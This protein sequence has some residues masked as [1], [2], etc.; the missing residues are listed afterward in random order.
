[1]DHTTWTDQTLSASVEV[2]DQEAAA[3]DIKTDEAAATDVPILM[4]MDLDVFNAAKEGKIDVLRGHDPQHLNQIL[5]PTSNTVLHVYIAYAITPKLVKPK[6]EAPIKPTSFV[7]D[8]LQ[9]CPT[10]LWQ[11]NKSGETALHMAAKHGLAEIV[12]LLIQTAK[13][14]RCED[15]E[16]GA[17]AFALSS[18]SEEEAASWKIFI[19]TP[20]K[21]KDT[22]LH[23]AVRFKHLGVVE[24]LIREDPDF[25]YP[26]N[27]AGE[28]PLYLAAERRYKALFSEIL[29]TCK[30]PTYQ[31]PIGRTALHAAVIHG[32]EEMT[33]EILNKK[34]D[35]AIVTDEKG[36]TPLHYAA[37]YG[38]ASIVTQLLEADK[39]SAYMGD[40]ADKKTALHIAA[41]K[42]HVN[43]MKQ[44]ISYCPDCCEVVDRRR[45]NALHYALEKRKPRIIEFVLMDTWLSNV[46]LNAKDVD[47]NTPLHLLNAPLY[48][49]TPF[50]GDDRVD[51][52]AFNKENMN[53]L[54]VIKANDDVTFK[55]YLAIVLKR[56]GASSGHRILSENDNDGQKLKENK[57]GEDTKGIKESHLVVAALVATVTFA[58]GVTMPGGY[59][60]ASDQ[61]NGTSNVS[62][63]NVTAPAPAPSNG[64]TPGYAV[65]TKNTAFQIFYSFDMI[66]LCFSTCSVFMHLFTLI[67][68]EAERSKFLWRFI[69][70]I[71]MVSVALMMG[72]FIAG[73][74]AVLGDDPS[75][76]Q[77][78]L[79]LVA[80]SIVGLVYVIYVEI[81][82]ENIFILQ[83]KLNRL[84]E[85]IKSRRHID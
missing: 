85:T 48:T 61:G 55:R 26:P 69:I 70:Q 59:Y 64:S 11:Q 68:P 45:R 6:E 67:R 42:G 34:K 17:A 1:M 58:A 32:D 29:G 54:D 71:T 14:R 74:Y 81:Q 22:A 77:S 60:Q 65:L 24:I 51:K 46:L 31:G 79:F 28:T 39:R 75:L 13:A 40:E 27:V 36:W 16:H 41:S 72:A 8:I 35:L 9:I 56:N 5:T 84:S 33:K 37:F 20:S 23:E 25:S 52:M 15:L 30:H 21:E 12:E 80:Y 66:A 18:S 62:R 73:A 53:A 44:L 50:I 10:L 82:P 76:A 63:Q 78:G 47:G 49:K 7:E 2:V 43:V 83:Y 3:T 38:R 57:G 4:G 19:R